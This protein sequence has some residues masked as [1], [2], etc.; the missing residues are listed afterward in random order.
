[1]NDIT[2]SDLTPG[3]TEPVAIDL[4]FTADP[5]PERPGFQAGET[6]AMGLRR[7]SVEQ[8]AIAIEQFFASDAD[9][10]ATVHE[11]RKALKRLRALLHLVRGHIG[12]V[13]FREENAVLRSAGRILAPVRDAW[14][15][16]ACVESLPAGSSRQVAVQ[17][18]LRSRLVERYSTVAAARLGDSQSMTDLSTTLRAARRRYMAWPVADARVAPAKV[19]VAHRFDTVEPGLTRVYDTG[20]RR[21]GKSRDD[22]SE[23]MFHNWRKQV[24]YLRHHIEMLEVIWPEVLGAYQREIARLARSLGDEHDLAL[25]EDLI[26]GDPD[27]VEHDHERFA[28][29]T[30]IAG[31]RLDLQATAT[32][33]GRLVYAEPTE[34]FIGRMAEYWRASPSP[35][36]F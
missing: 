36:C 31:R 33:Q 3:D 12:E 10:T 24:K 34:S 25:L 20:R 19:R 30:T 4:T 28:L 2:T 26:A 11:S 13:A 29:L 5:R 1:M 32:T 15:M 27:L 21:L 6:L 35:D 14:V 8:F 17:D 18:T 16:I 23:P 22:P 7:I 9:S